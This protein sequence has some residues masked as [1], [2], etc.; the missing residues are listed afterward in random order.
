MNLDKKYQKSIKRGV[1]MPECSC[2][3]I[4]EK[5][6][7][8]KFF[9]WTGKV[10]Y[11]QSQPLFFHVPV[12]IDTRMNKLMMD[13]E[14]SGYKIKGPETVIQEDSMF[15]G[16]IMIEIEDPKTDDNNLIR[17]KERTRIYSTVFTESWDK[18]ARGVR[19]VTKKLQKKKMKVTKVYF[20]HL[21]CPECAKKRGYKT[22]IFCKVKEEKKP[23]KKE[24]IKKTGKKPQKIKKR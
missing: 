3:I 7:I 1:S 2:P 9:D 15:K 12:N 10:F 18:L 6:F 22:V 17:F 20:M 8:N 24:S 16:K 11:T 13:V 4:N 14:S 23:A 19:E 21:T 5:K